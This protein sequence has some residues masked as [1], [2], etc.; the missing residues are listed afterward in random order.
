MHWGASSKLSQVTSWLLS[1]E[2]GIEDVEYGDREGIAGKAWFIGGSVPSCSM[3]SC[4]MFYSSSRDTLGMSCKI[5]PYTVLF[6]PLFNDKLSHTYHCSWALTSLICLTYHKAYDL[7]S[8]SYK[9]ACRCWMWRRRWWMEGRWCCRK[10][11]AGRRGRDFCV[12]FIK[13]EIICLVHHFLHFIHKFL[14]H[15]YFLHVQR[16]VV[17]H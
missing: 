2:P 11:L 15:H 9:P 12:A 16:L 14:G 10:E 8:S 4:C 7:L 3:S 17:F 5:I 1:N 13:W 6:R